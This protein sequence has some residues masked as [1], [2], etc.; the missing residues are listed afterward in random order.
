M[1]AKGAIWH[2]DT[3]AFRDKREDLVTNHDALTLPQNY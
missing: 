3:I 2:L 1:N